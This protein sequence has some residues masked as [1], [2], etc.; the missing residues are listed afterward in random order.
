MLQSGSLS[1]FGHPIPAIL[2]KQNLDAQQ[3]PGVL[4]A[5]HVGCGDVPSCLYIVEKNIYNRCQAGFLKKQWLIQL[6]FNS[7]ETATTLYKTVK[8]DVLKIVE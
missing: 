2:R 6:S 5:V 8:T 7:N 4:K 3:G 1:F